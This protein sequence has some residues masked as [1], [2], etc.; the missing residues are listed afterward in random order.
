MLIVDSVRKT[1]GET[2]ALA[3][4]SLQ[5]HPRE[6]LGIVG[7]N[8]AG[9]STL[10]KLL[11]GEEREDSGTISYNDLVL[12]LERRRQLVAVVHQEPQ[13]FPNLSVAAN[14]MIGRGGIA[15]P[16]PTPE[17]VHLL[18]H[19]HVG[20]QA[21]ELLENTPIAVWQLTEIARALL[22]SAEVFVFDEPNSALTKDE[23]QELFEH[24]KGLRDAGKLVILV[25]HRL[26]EV[27]EICERVVAVRDGSVAGVISGHDVTTENLA[28]ILTAQEFGGGDSAAIAAPF[29][30]SDAPA[31]AHITT[32]PGGS[33]GGPLPGTIAENEK[34][35]DAAKRSIC[36]IRG[37][38]VAVTGPE[39]GGGR[40]LVRSAALAGETGRVRRAYMP[41]D[42]RQSLFFNMSVAA[43]IASR[44]NRREL[45]GR[46]RL[47]TRRIIAKAAGSYIADFRIKAAQPGVIVG[48]LSGGNQQKVALACALAVRPDLLIVEEPTRGVDLATKIQIHEILGTFARSGGAVVMFVNELEDAVGCA[49][50]LFVVG[51]QVVQGCLDVDK[52]SDLEALTIA[53]SQ[54]L[55]KQVD[56]A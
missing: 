39:G 13:L 56:A 5:A 17:V 36:G 21:N 38:V 28:S 29:I 46:R 15:K 25:S 22:R 14:L 18:R 49:D 45:S 7:A 23:S 41:A 19:L 4:L 12:P 24:M 40:E 47:I 31:V 33:G 52:S 11:A 1:Y 42:R 32:A 43:N 8:G 2:H 37:H 34:R 54:L 30:A 3:S 9:K 20:G 55:G 16:R 53:V 6:I 48:S 44:L 10:V 35:S 50:R 26:A 51:D 27:S